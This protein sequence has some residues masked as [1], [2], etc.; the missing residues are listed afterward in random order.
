MSIMN[1]HEGFSVI[2]FSSNLYKIGCQ[3]SFEFK[4]LKR[5]R[6][7]N[8]YLCQLAIISGLKI[9]YSIKL[10]AIFLVKL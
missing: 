10:F 9:R 2:F 3:Y 4:L 7:L 1:K 6:E 8:S 5:F